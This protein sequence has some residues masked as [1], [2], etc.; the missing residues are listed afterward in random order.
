MNMPPNYDITKG[1]VMDAAKMAL[2]T[3]NVNY[4]LIWVPEASEN[5]LKNLFDKTVCEHRDRKDVQDIALDWYFET[6]SRLHRSRKRVL[7]TFMK[8][9]G[10]DESQIF[11]KVERAIEIG[12]VEELIGDIPYTKEGDLRQRFRH[13]MD[14]R[15]Y[16]V[17][18]IAAGRAYVSAFID[19]IIYVHNLSTSIPGEEGHV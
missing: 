8:P 2:D 10:L 17:N 4:V 18:N 1:L 16:D 7:Y 14:K 12:D 15:N 11:Q 5:K 3:G 9:D 6:V 19:F 13:V